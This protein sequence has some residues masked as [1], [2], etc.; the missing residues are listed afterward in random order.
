RALLPCPPGT[1]TISGAVNS[2]SARSAS[3]PREPVSVRFGPA[4]FATKRSSAPGRRES[5][6]YGPMASRAVSRSKIR[7]AICTSPTL[8]M[9]G[10]TGDSTPS[11]A[12]DDNAGAVGGAPDALRSRMVAPQ[13][14]ERL[15]LAL[16]R[17][18]TAESA[19]H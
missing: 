8:P 3:T 10:Q 11:R 16:G 2:A 5:T 4:S 15:I 17:D 12:P 18:Q 13:Q 14:L 9:V 7:I 19:A 6:S 1:N